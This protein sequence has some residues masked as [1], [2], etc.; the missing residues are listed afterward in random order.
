[1]YSRNYRCGRSRWRAERGAERTG[2]ALGRRRE[3]DR[4]RL[5]PTIA[6]RSSVLSCETTELAGS[7]G[8]QAVVFGLPA[9]SGGPGISRKASQ[10]RH[11][12]MGRYTS[13]DRV[14]DRPSGCRGR[15]ARCCRRHRRRRVMQDRMDRRETRF[16]VTCDRL[17]D[18]RNS[19]AGQRRRPICNRNK[20]QVRLDSATR[21][22]GTG[23]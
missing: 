19:G 21:P 5:L 3:A 10:G 17:D 12:L 6:R 8:A 16:D 1:V 20:R 15:S 11:A 2:T 22:G 4:R 13:G 18:K 9:A 7:A 23:L 14:I